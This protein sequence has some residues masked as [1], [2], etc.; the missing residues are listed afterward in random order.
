MV[1]RVRT[2]P[3]MPSADTAGPLRYS[4]SSLG[5]SP[6][7]CAAFQLMQLN[8]DPQSRRA[9]TG[10]CCCCCCCWVVLVLVLVLGVDDDTRI[11]I[12]ML[13]L[14]TAAG[15]STKPDASAVPGSNSRIR[16]LGKSRSASN[17]D[18]NSIPSIPSTGSWAGSM[19]SWGNPVTTAVNFGRS[20]AVP[21]SPTSMDAP[22]NS[23]TGF[24]T[25]E[26]PAASPDNLPRSSCIPKI[27]WRWGVINSV[28]RPESTMKSNGPRSPTLS[29]SAMYSLPKPPPGSLRRTM[30]TS[31]RGGFVWVVLVWI[32]AAA[33][34]LASPE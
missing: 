11:P 15:I 18:S 6:R 24:E 17:S 12:S 16:F 29:L 25:V 31:T 19:C 4:G 8:V 23:T 26:P 22:V 27:P 3:S 20:R 30:G 33:L 1:G 28:V 10:C 7:A 14:T 9:K 34:A 32:A 2:P 21:P 13:S 5:G